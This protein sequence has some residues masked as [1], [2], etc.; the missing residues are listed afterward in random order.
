MKHITAPF[1]DDQ[2]KNMRAWQESDQVHPFTCCDHQ[3]MT[4]ETD[5]FHCPKCGQVQTW[6]HEIMASGWKPRSPFPPIPA[7]AAEG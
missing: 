6:A 5:G 1:T 2:V 7:P 3:T 4:V